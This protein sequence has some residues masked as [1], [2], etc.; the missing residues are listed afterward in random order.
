M[1]EKKSDWLTR[2]IGRCINLDKA[3]RHWGK[4]L[5]G[6]IV[7]YL[8][9]MPLLAMAIFDAYRF[10][11]AGSQV[12]QTVLFKIMLYKSMWFALMIGRWVLFIYALIGLAR[13]WQ[14]KAPNT[15][16]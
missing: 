12:D 4:A 11:E 1:D 16:S 13:A 5:L 7:L 9:K 2:N 8:A 6:A 3:A 15:P 14:S 10:I